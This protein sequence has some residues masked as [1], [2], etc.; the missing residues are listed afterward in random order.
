[1]PI[2]VVDENDFERELNSLNTPNPSENA[3]IEEL[4]HGRGKDTSNVPDP[5]RKIIGEEVI[6]NGH[7]AGTELAKTLG[8]SE[9]S[10]S[11]YQKGATSTASINKPDPGL[12]DHINQA[13]REVARKAREKLELAIDS[14]TP[15]K[16]EDASVRVAS[17][18]AKDMS[19]VVRDMEP[20]IA[21]D[22]DKGV[23]FVFLVPPMKT[24]EQF[25]VIDVKD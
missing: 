1:M 23:K 10:V 19:A 25:E 5:I 9:S 12:L 7:A 2:G 14:I 22:S 18:V 11:A 8:I 20:A 3:R 21:E 13:K 17:G 24:E 6:N 15:A 16:L 4:K